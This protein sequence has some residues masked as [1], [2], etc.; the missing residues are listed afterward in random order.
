MS[1][2][3]V[4]GIEI[5]PERIANQKLVTILRTLEEHNGHKDHHDRSYKDH[6]DYSDWTDYSEKTPCA[7]PPGR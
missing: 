2:M 6:T 1:T 7:G 4:R 3:M 5:E